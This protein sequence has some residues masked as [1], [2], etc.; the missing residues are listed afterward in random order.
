[1]KLSG[2]I[3]LALILAA[4]LAFAGEQP[5]KTQQDK[6]NYSI[7]VSTIRNFKQ[8]GTGKEINLEM[9]IRGMKDELSGKQ[10]LM[11]EKELRSA[12]T[13]VQTEIM[14]RKRTAR[15]ATAFKGSSAPS[16]T[17]NARP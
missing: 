17:G 4:S 12:L 13:A 3:V 5:L 9:L 7:G 8:Y 16:D 6:I 14:Q 1:M 11:S 2:V 15:S 10:L